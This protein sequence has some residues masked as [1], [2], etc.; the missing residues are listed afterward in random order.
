MILVTIFY[1]LGIVFVLLA[2]Y[3]RYWR[4]KRKSNKRIAFGVETFI[5]YESFILTNLLEY[6]IHFLYYF[7]FIVGVIILFTTYF[8]ARD[9][10]K[11]THW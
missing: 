11:V 2:F 7:L 3:F 9:L 6:F 10:M 1:V 4:R 5:L 8:G